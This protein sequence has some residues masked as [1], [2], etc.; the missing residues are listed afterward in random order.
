MLQLPTSSSTMA[1]AKIILYG[2][3]P[4]RWDARARARSLSQDPVAVLP[5]LIEFRSSPIIAPSVGVEI[6]LVNVPD[7]GTRALCYCRSSSRIAAILRRLRG[8]RE[9]GDAAHRI[10]HV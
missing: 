6:V 3:E 2:G 9:H 4:N 8:N 10:L 7:C 1:R 5:C